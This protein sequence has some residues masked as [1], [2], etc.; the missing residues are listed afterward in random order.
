VANGY[1][2]G[3]REK[4]T[5]NKRT[6]ELAERLEALDCDPVARLANLANDPDLDP[7]IR[8]RCCIELM[9]YLYPKRKAIEFTEI[10]QPEPDDRPDLG[11]LTTDELE[12]MSTI[13]RARDERE[14]NG[15]DKPGDYETVEAYE[16]RV[17]PSMPA[18]ERER[19]GENRGGI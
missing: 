2:T 17:R 15:W 11:Y 16:A 6:V 4:G 5:P 10:E 18:E 7:A 8:A 1:K 3:G 19:N 12:T 13:L 14:R 9:A